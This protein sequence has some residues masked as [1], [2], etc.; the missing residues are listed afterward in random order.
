MINPTKLM[1]LLDPEEKQNT[2]FFQCHLPNDDYCLCILSV[3]NKLDYTI[4][5]SIQFEDLI[6]QLYLTPEETTRKEYESHRRDK[7]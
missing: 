3:P 4:L 6:G 5:G 2:K 1:E 7:C